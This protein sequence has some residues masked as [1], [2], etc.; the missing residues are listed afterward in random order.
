MVKLIVNVDRNAYDQADFLD[1]M[2][3]F[4][5]ALFNG[6]LIGSTKIFGHDFLWLLFGLAGI[7]CWILLR[8]TGVNLREVR[9]AEKLDALRYR[10]L[11][12]L[13]G[14][15]GDEDVRRLKAAGLRALAWKLYREL[16]PDTPTLRAHENYKA[17]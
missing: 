4:C 11:Y 16:H 13:P 17:L 8:R 14:Q 1:R 2:S 5:F 10:G 12:P 3:D 6:A 7:V 15:G 9:A